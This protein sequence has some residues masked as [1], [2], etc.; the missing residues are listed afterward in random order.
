MVQTEAGDGVVMISGPDFTLVTL[1]AK[2]ET[3]ER[4]ISS[5]SARLVKQS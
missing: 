5:H 1:G 2:N 4:H 3:T